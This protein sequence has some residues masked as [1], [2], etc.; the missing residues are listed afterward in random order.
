MRGVDR[1]TSYHQEAQWLAL[2]QAL[3]I[4]MR[5]NNSA[6]QGGQEQT[7]LLAV[8]SES[9]PVLA[10]GSQMAS[11]RPPQATSCQLQFADKAGKH[12]HREDP[13]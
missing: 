10:D 8:L 11:A 6:V 13:Q 5:S 7:P 1:G 4:F 2:K 12:P 9:I 3:L